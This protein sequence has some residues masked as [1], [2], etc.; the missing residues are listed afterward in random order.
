MQQNEGSIIQTKQGMN[1]YRNII[2]N[3]SFFG[4]VQ[5]I[6]ILI[7]LI[8]GKFVAIIL[9][10][11]GM[12]ISALFNSSSNTIQR[13]SS[14]GLPQTITKDVADNT[15]SS[16]QKNQIITTSLRLINLTGLLGFIFC[17]SLCY[18][19]SK[20]T[21]GDYAYWWQ[22]IILGVGIWFGVAGN[23][24]LSILQGL[25]ETKRISFASVV[26]GITG[27]CVGIPLYY[28][29]G[30]KGIVP[31]I[32]AIFLSLYI[33]YSVSLKR[34]YSFKPTINKWENLIPIA[35]KL[36]SLG[37]ILMSGDIIA[38]LFTYLINLYIRIFGSLD[39]VGLYQAAYSVTKQFS[40][41]I[42]TI[43]AMDYFP[44]LAGV[45][46]N[47][48][49]MQDVVN[50]QSEVVSWLMTPA[51]TLLI[52]SSPLLISIFL[53][54]EFHPIIPLMRWMGLGMLCRAFSYPMAYITFAK[55][56]K[57]VFFILEG[58]IANSLTL[59]LSCLFFRWYGLIGLGYALVADNVLCFILYYI[60][61]NHLYNYKFTTLSA[62][63]FFIGLLL[64]TGCFIFS[65]FHDPALSYTL[66]GI[67]TFLSLIWSFIC[68]KR[69][70]KT[71]D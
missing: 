46:S 34:S 44:R 38:T 30:N 59:V 40:G 47:N 13:F 52:L 18:P 9:G 64:V 63:N 57:K 56:N 4:G 70:F 12:G 3:S 2:K 25:H 10:P 71:T 19:L 28:I 6:N 16:D 60:V 37:I 69:H 23:G 65:Y 55:G 61:N 21:F 26:G 54:S 67:I 58:I 53:S 36:L 32:V 50:R 11:D 51:M 33:F 15:L 43:L 49:K 1:S 45:A 8:R 29:F 42:F 35:K 20:I 66:M 41:V 27:L 14:L 48:Q 39:D 22:F 5:I 31:A 62:F 17:A 24:K 7:T 68:L